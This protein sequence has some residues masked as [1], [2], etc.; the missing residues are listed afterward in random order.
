MRFVPLVLTIVMVLAGSSAFG[1]YYLYHAEEYG[2]GVD[3]S[4]ART[5]EVNSD[6]FRCN[7]QERWPI[8][9]LSRL[10]GPR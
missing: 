9:N 2:F 4:R 7:Y 3:Y 8:G 5:G 10:F 1:Q 6:G